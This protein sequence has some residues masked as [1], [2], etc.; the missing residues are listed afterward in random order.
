MRFQIYRSPDARFYWRMLSRNHRIVATAAEG[1]ASTEDVARAAR[2]VRTHATTAAIDLTSVQ[3]GEWQWTMRVGGRPVAVSAHGYGR[4][5]EA[6]AA[7]DRFRAGARDAEVMDRVIQIGGA[8]GQP[9]ERSQPAGE[10]DDGWNDR[11]W[12]SEGTA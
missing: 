7:A 3:G 6:Q 10:D 1:F 4:R 8:G 11:D 5:L 9:G 2:A 12:T